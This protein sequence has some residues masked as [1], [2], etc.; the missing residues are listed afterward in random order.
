MAADTNSYATSSELRPSA[1]DPATR[2]GIKVVPFGEE[3]TREEMGTA[4]GTLVRQRPLV[5]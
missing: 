3:L 2:T 1:Y 5:R 4:A